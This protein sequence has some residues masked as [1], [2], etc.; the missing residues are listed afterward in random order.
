MVRFDFDRD[1]IARIK[2]TKSGEYKEKG[3][4][5]LLKP[6]EAALEFLNEAELQLDDRATKK[7]IEWYEKLLIKTGNRSKRKE[8]AHAIAALP[9]ASVLEQCHFKDIDG[10]PC[11]P[12]PYQW[13][14][15]H[16]APLNNGC[17][18][19]LDNMGGGKSVEAIM[20][21]IRKEYKKHPVLIVCP[22]SLIG[23]WQNEIFKM[24]E[25][26]SVVVNKPLGRLDPDIRF[27]IVSYYQLHK[28]QCKPGWFVVVDEIHNFRNRDT[29]RS[30]DLVKILE[31]KK[32][33]IGLTGTPVCNRPKDLFP[34]MDWID[35]GFYRWWD[36]ALE[37]CGAQKGFFGWTTD[38][39]TNLDKLNAM[40]YDDFAIRRTN[41]Q[42]MS[43]LPEKI[44]QVVNLSPRREVE[45]ETVMGMFAASAEAKSKDGEF[46]ECVEDALT[47][48]D[49]VIIFAHH[50]TMM[51][52]MAKVCTKLGL[53]YVRI[54]GSVDSSKRFAL[55][56]QFQNE[57]DVHVI[58]L[59]ITAAS[60]GLNLQR[61]NCIIFAELYWMATTLLQAEARAHRPG[62]K[63][64]LLCLYLLWGAREQDIHKIVMQK[65][66]V[67]EKVVDGKHLD[68][69]D[70]G[71]IKL[72]A[73]QWG[74]SAGV[75]KKD[76][77]RVGKA[78]GQRE[79]ARSSA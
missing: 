16:Y 63:H 36:F 45:S 74:C 20:V 23:N 19:I 32:Y 58:L 40:L 21:T 39:A 13:V 28:V 53:K 47:S 2:K 78:K 38:G 60:E 5:W 37:F 27:Y 30:K 77:S 35:P 71:M 49:K 8:L 31:F 73:S 25:Q 70:Q 52:A 75:V 3:K 56:E 57:P 69:D 14:P 42:I 59:S 24:F 33:L 46:L 76:E 34:S 67:A 41:D 44:R 72:L 48:L 26:E 64:S 66:G 9:I 55:C 11:E 79:R 15:C 4:Y 29:K 7:L 62:L 43:Q 68:L 18:L 22:P 54:D 12:R 51:D 17:M 6:T 61:A 65:H 1:I 10:N 50:K